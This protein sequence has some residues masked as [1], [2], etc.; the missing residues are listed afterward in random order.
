DRAS[1]PAAVMGAVTLLLLAGVIDEGQAFSGFSNPAPITVAALYVLSAAAQA[2]GIVELLTARILGPAASS[3]LTDRQVLSRILI[4][5]TMASAFLNNTPIV[6]M[7]APGV[8]SWAR[9]AGR[10]VSQFLMPVSFASIL[11]GVITAIGTST[12]L[13]VSGLLVASD[14]EPLGLFEIGQ[15]GLPAA[16]A[17]LVVVILLAPRALAPRRAPGERMGDDAREFTVEMTLSNGSPLAGKTVAAAGL[18]N[19]EGVF[20]VEVERSGYRIAPVSPDE[21]LVTGD[22]LTFAGNVSRVLD[23][24]RLPGL[25]SAEQP[26]FSF[27]GSAM[28]RRM[29]EAVVGEDSALAGSSLKEVGFRSRYGG[30]VLA[31]H[32]A[33]ER[34]DAKLGEVRLHPGDV[35]LVLS[36]ADFRRR[37]NDGRDF[38]VIA[39]LDGETPPRRDK[40]VVVGVVVVALLALVGTGVLDILQAALV[41]AFSLVVFRVLSPAEA[42]NAVDLNVIVVIAGSFGLGEAVSGSGLAQELADTIIEPLGSLGDVGLLIGVL[43]ATVL[44]TEL[45]TNNAAAVLVF[46]IA[47]AV[48]SQSGLD[49]RPFAMAIALAASAS[50]LT[51]IGYQTNTMVYG[52]GGYRFGDF[53]RLGL[54]L[55]LI[56]LAIGTFVIPVFWPLTP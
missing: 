40:A 33:G 55:T 18:R 41:A 14:Q 53:A 23:L 50:F 34:I 22:R 10:S 43:L 35:L 21:V 5:T 8:I 15:V 42:R 36:D 28:R 48:A 54:P 27:A 32:R 56:V 24:Q 38:L 45:I 25:T 30:A 4:P 2:T 37:W 31:I 13:V 44:L 29:F 51:P 52:M 11:G 7:V 1:P 46:P 9:R 16:I 3:N 17:G 20:L 6:A 47:M 49:P 12:N 26:H 39:P 19:L